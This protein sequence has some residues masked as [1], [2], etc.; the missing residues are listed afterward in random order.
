MVLGP[1]NPAD[2]GERNLLRLVLSLMAADAQMGL[3]VVLGKEGLGAGS[4][5]NLPIES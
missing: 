3:A 2:V 4:S 5:R 1:V